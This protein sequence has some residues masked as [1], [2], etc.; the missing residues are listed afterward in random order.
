MRFR[1]GLEGTF[2]YERREGRSSCRRRYAGWNEWFTWALR[3]VKGPAVL[4]RVRD[5]GSGSPLSAVANEALAYV[6]AL[7]K[8]CEQTLI[9]VLEQPWRRSGGSEGGWG[10]QGGCELGPQ[11]RGRRPAPPGGRC[12]SLTV[13]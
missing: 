8:G 5:Q 12:S 3:G 11:P 10:A 4:C 6:D 13:R 2:A 1:K 9:E 7:E